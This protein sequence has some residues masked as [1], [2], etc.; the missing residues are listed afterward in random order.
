MNKQLLL[1]SVALSKKMYLVIILGV[2]LSLAESLIA[3]YSPL[4]SNII[5]IFDV[6]YYLSI[7]IYLSRALEGKN[8]RLIEL[9]KILWATTKKSFWPTLMLGLSIVVVTFVLFFVA[10]RVFGVYEFQE[11][12]KNPQN[13]Y[14]WTLPSLTIQLI[15]SIIFFLSATL[16]IYFSIKK[17][18]LIK[19]YFESAKF[20]IKNFKFFFV[21][22]ILTT[23]NLL[24]ARI[25]IPYTSNII[26]ST[27]YTIYFSI[28]IILINSVYFLY[29][30]KSEK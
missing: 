14:G 17:Y 28:F 3:R 9:L 27:I 5:Y 21:V 25:I 30:Q 22:W 29:F 10:M 11:F 18:G 8:T 26:I 16:P 13:I 19:S 15:I 4:A 6:G 20:S 23:P 12:L 2:L 24:L 7:P 1:D